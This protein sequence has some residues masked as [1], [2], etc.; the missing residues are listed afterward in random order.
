MATWAIAYPEDHNGLIRLRANFFITDVP[1]DADKFE[2]EV[3]A[4]DEMNDCDRAVPEDAWGAALAR[5]ADDDSIPKVRWRGR[6][7]RPEIGPAITVRLEED[8]LAA[9]DAEAERARETRAAAIR[10][11]LRSALARA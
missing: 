5:D 2:V 4:C 3:W 10:R 7:G 11:L 8:L 1:D 9:V 6:P